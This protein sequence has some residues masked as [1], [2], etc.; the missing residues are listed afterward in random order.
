MGSNFVGRS[1]LQNPARGRVSRTE[2]SFDGGDGYSQRSNVGLREASIGP[3][4][5]VKINAGE[6]RREPPTSAYPM[7]G[8][9]LR[10]TQGRKVECGEREKE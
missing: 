2:V 3:S 8:E 6:K 9:F 4:T 5:K 10:Q 1:F 7:G